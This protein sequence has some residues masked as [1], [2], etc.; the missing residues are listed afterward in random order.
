MIKKDFERARQY[1]YW[2]KILYLYIKLIRYHLCYPPW[3]LIEKMNQTK[4]I[5]LKSL[6][7]I[8]HI[9]TPDLK[10]LHLCMLLHA[11]QRARV[12]F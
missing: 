4:F 10:T 7:K 1:V 8:Y 6:D 2:C 11:L 5:I 12:L 3:L 9:Q